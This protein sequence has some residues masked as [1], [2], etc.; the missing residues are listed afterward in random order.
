MLLRGN[1]F[2]KVFFIVMITSFLLTGCGG[3]LFTH[4]GDKVTQ[5]D[6]MVLLKDGNQQGVW[7]NYELAIK[8]QYQMTS[9]TLK[10]SGTT[11]LVGGYRSFSRLAVY[12]LFLDNQGIVV[13]DM[14][15]YSAANYRPMVSNPMDFEKIIPIPE[16]ARTISFAYDLTSVYGK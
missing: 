12:L 7:K 16:G 1:Q 3:K 6:L 2:V 5:K 4:K 11:E 14:L 13:E 15:I 8:Y 10:F 9:E